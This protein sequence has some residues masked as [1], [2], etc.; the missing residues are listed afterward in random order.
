MTSTYFSF[1]SLG[2]FLDSAAITLAFVYLRIGRKI[3]RQRLVYIELLAVTS[4]SLKT[5]R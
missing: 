5:D 2:V 3:L 1:S 4:R